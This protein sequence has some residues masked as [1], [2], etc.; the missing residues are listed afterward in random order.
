M[1]LRILILEH[2]LTSET[3]EYLFGSF[4]FSLEGGLVAD[5]QCGVRLRGLVACWWPASD[6]CVEIVSRHNC[7]GGR[8]GF[9]DKQD[10]LVRADF[11]AN[12]YATYDRLGQEGY[13]R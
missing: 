8:M 2:W 4:H 12:T 7:T 9:S 13:L 10:L 3:R 1:P 6:V 5:S 11:Y